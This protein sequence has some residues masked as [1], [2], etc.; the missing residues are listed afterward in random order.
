ML[1]NLI[2]LLSISCCT[3]AIAQPRADAKPPAAAGQTEA[4]I[5]Y[6]LIGADMPPL[7]LEKVIDSG[8]V[9]AGLSKY[10]KD[11][12]PRFVSN[13]DLN[14]K[15]NLFVMMF[16]PTC[17]HCMDETE[18]LERNKDLFKK[19]KLVMIAMHG[20]KSYMQHFVSLMKV[21]DYPFIIIGTDSTKRVG[22]DSSG[23]INK[24]F[25][26]SALPQI[27]IYDKKRKL[28]KSFTGE[29]AI[30]SLKQYIQ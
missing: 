19:S 1:R 14:Q 29:V 18:M 7:F 3:T 13:E 9:K 20:M 30:D 17:S 25:L 26:Y 23:F 11:S 5:D 4:D 24:V 2:I 10:P 27:N 8:R 15:A 12:E 28:L 22:N 6:K 16:N 21:E